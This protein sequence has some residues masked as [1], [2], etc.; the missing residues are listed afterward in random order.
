MQ[1][2]TRKKRS[3][4]NSLMAILGVVLVAVITISGTLAFLMDTDTATNVFTVGKFDISLTESDFIASDAIGIM[5][6]DTIAKTPIITVATGS[7]PGYIRFKVEITKK[8]GNIMDP[9]NDAARIAKIYSLFSGSLFLAGQDELKTPAL[10]YVLTLNES[11]STSSVLYYEA[12]IDGAGNDGVYDAGETITLFTGLVVPTEWTQTDFDLVGNFKIVVTAQ[13]IQAANLEDA[14][15][16]FA[17]LNT[18]LGIVVP[19]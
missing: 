4:K 3:N 19:E 14:C 7:A 11:I 17:A 6:G 18:Q 15:T 5:P 1:D 2:K 8:N 12:L 13:G 9:V 16:A 10:G